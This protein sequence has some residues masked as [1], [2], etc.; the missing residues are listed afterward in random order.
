MALLTAQICAHNSSACTIPSTDIVPFPDPSNFPYSRTIPQLVPVPKSYSR[1]IPR[2]VPFHSLY[3]START[4]P[5]LVPFPSSF[6]SRTIPQLVPFP[7]S[8]ILVLFRSSYRSIEMWPLPAQFHKR[9]HSDYSTA[10]PQRWAGT[11]A[12]CWGPVAK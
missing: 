6:I 9:R 7:S 2:L 4:I 1:T 11:S 12:W 5:Q 3:H 8:T 10:N